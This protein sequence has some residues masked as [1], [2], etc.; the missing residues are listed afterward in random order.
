MHSGVSLVCVCMSVCSVIYGEP[1]CMAPV[2]LKD[3]GFIL[4]RGRRGRGRQRGNMRQPSGLLSL[5]SRILE[6]HRGQTGG[7]GVVG[8][9]GATGPSTSET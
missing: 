2:S 9:L 8:F 5:L 1:H 7:E 3:K 4:R 6:A